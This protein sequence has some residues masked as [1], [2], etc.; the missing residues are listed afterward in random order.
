MTDRADSGEAS[1]NIPT[2]FTID[3]GIAKGVAQ[4][5]FR[6]LKKG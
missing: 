4:G 5:G 3:N 2:S 6:G 1:F